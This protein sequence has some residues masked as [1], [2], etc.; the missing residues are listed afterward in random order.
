MASMRCPHCAGEI[1]AG[2][3][4][5]GICGRNITVS[6]GGATGAGAPAVT[7]PRRWGAGGVSAEAEDAD[8]SMSLFELP[9]SRRARRLKVALVLA[10]DAILAAAGIIMIL[11][12]LE[13]REAP[14]AA[15]AV[16]P[17]SGGA[18]GGAAG[19]DD[20]GVVLE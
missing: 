9:V 11:S 8:L 4:F 12:Y 7:D 5:C 14:A 18:A 1:P 20:A 10:L 16:A 13:A 3:R 2:S 6:P 17:V 19:R 15:P